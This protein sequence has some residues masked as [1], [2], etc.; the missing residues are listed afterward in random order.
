MCLTVFDSDTQLIFDS[1]GEGTISVIHEANPD[2]SSRN[3]Q[4]SAPSQ[5]LQLQI[6]KR[7][8][9]STIESEQFEV[10]VVEITDTQNSRGETAFPM[11]SCIHFPGSTHYGRW[12]PTVFIEGT[13]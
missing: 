1:N 2:K 4:A 6:Q 5:N 8:L 7:L 12:C 3:G 10:V 11:H 9:L 13:A